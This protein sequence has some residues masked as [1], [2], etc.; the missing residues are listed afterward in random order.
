MANGAARSRPIYSV[1]EQG[2]ICEKTTAGL[3]EVQSE[4]AEQEWRVCHEVLAWR[5]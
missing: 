3:Q 4:G 2:F 1:E 5:K